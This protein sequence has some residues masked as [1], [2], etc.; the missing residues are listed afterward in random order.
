M[1]SFASLIAEM[2]KLMQMAL[3]PDHNNCCLIDF[4]KDNMDIQL[5][6]EQGT[7]LLIIGSNISK[8]PPGRYRQNL[9]EQALKANNLEIPRG[10]ILAF[11]PKSDMMVLFLKIPTKDLTAQAAVGLLPPFKEKFLRWREAISKNET[12]PLIGVISTKQTSSGMFGL[13]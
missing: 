5:E 6:M 2:G 9:F 11:S 3:K 7:D 13:R 4:P 12:P 1:D 10:G 8:I